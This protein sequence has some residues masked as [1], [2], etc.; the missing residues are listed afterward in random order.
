MTNHYLYTKL[1]GFPNLWLWA[2]LMK[3][4][5]KRTARTKLDIYVY[6]HWLVTANIWTV[7]WQTTIFMLNYLVFQPFG[8]ECTWWRLIQ[9]RNVRTKLDIYVYIIILLEL[10]TP[11]YFLF[12]R[13]IWITRLYTNLRKWRRVHILIRICI[14]RL[15]LK[16]TKFNNWVGCTTNNVLFIHSSRRMST[17]CTFQLNEYILHFSAKCMTRKSKV[18]EGRFHSVYVVFW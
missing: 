6:M 16:P 18:K 17:F 15:L 12:L 8:C 14:F 5:Q 13:R 2:Y 11:E 1:F 9:K 7:E 4:I 3:L 10:D